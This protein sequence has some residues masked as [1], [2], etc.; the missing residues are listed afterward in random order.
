[1]TLHSEVSQNLKF[2]YISKKT[3]IPITFLSYI[4]G[5]IVREGLWKFTAAI[6]KHLKPLFL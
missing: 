1:M 6:A 4:F 2:R 3:I 5:V